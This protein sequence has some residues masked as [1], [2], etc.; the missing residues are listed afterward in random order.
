MKIFLLIA[1][2]TITFSYCSNLKKDDFEFGPSYN[3]VRQKFGSPRIKNNMTTQNCCGTQTV[4]EISEIPMNDKAY[5]AS[6]TIRAFSNGKVTEEKDIYRKSIDDTT[7][8]QVD[9][10]SDWIWEENKISF[11]GKIGKIDKRTLNLNAKEFLTK[12]SSFPEYSWTKLKLNEIDSS[13][14]VWGLSR[15]DDY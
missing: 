12:H 10:L 9:I 7:L 1:T 5:H 11:T 2:L 13:L 6:K 8:V 3:T 15:N 4:Y 14:K